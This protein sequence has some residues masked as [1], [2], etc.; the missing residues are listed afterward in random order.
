[1]SSLEG[2]WRNSVQQHKQAHRTAVDKKV[3]GEA[4]NVVVVGDSECWWD[5]K[6]STADTGMARLPLQ[7]LLTCIGHIS[8]M[9]HLVLPSLLLR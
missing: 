9:D 7:P 8:I 6:H 1:M 3:G 2:D 4:G 5:C